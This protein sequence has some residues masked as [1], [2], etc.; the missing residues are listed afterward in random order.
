MA[1]NDR[2]PD[3]ATRRAGRMLACKLRVAYELVS[4]QDKS[5]F[6]TTVLYVTE[7]F[8]VDPDGLD[9]WFMR[10][11]FSM[12]EVHRADADVL[13]HRYEVERA[14]TIARL[15]ERTES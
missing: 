6:P 15:Y 12:Q 4:A 5:P 14:V 10:V 1:I 9:D 3:E 7:R 11:A 2:F 13:R 8:I